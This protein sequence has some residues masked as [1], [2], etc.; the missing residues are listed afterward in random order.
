MKIGFDLDGTLDKPALLK[1][2]KDL[3]AAGHEIH[4]ITGVFPESNALLQAP[5]K[6]D[7]LVRMGLAKRVYVPA[8]A[9]PP[10]KKRKGR[11]KPAVV[12]ITQPSYKWEFEKGVFVHVITAMPATYDREY[13]LVD[14]A[15]TKAALIEALGV[16]IMFDDSELYCKHMPAMCGAQILRVI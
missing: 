12:A 15:F 13:R 6:Y 11:R 10:I 7:K 8:E 1:L 2:A 4:I 14:V 5:G 16:E 9:P 3:L